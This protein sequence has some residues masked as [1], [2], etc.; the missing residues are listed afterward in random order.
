MDEQVP[1]VVYES[2]YDALL[3][4]RVTV[5]RLPANERLDDPRI[6]PH[7]TSSKRAFFFLF[8]TTV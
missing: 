7:P 1:A 3:Q 6:P 8:K 5:V 4:R 2:V